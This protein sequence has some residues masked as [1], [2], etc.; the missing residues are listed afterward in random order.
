VVHQH[1][2]VVLDLLEESFVLVLDSGLLLSFVLLDPHVMGLLF[3][4]MHVQAV[5]AEF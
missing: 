5:L 2:L 3:V 1:L 4:L